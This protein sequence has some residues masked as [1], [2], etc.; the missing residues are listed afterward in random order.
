MGK[1]KSNV[2]GS[3]ADFFLFVMIILCIYFIL[4]LF[5]SSLAGDSGQS[6][7]RT[8][9]TSFG[10]A[11]IVLL[12]FWLYLCIALFIKVIFIKNVNIWS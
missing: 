2:K 8:L 9:R 11:A 4:S 10:G 5:G 7:G 3:W 12:L 6:L 1:R